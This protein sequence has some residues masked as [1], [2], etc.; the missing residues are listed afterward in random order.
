[1]I[2][3]ALSLPSF[4]YF[5]SYQ[6]KQPR[7]DAQHDERK[8]AEDTE[9]NA[10][11]FGHNYLPSF[12]HL[13]TLDGDSPVCAAISFVVKSGCSFL[14]ASS[15]RRRSSTRTPRNFCGARSN[16]FCTTFGTFSSVFSIA[17]TSASGAGGGSVSFSPVWGSASITLTLSV[18]ARAARTM[19]RC[20]PVSSWL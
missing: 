6:D 19:A 8:D 18:D 9:H 12:C 15:T 7:H 14:S 11:I 1:M 13:R 5:L 3:L 10:L 16:I 17:S 2:M 4:T 20:C